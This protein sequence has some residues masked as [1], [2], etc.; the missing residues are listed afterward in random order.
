MECFALD[1]LSI[2]AWPA[3][4]SPTACQAIAST[5][6][7]PEQ[8]RSSQSI[9]EDQGH[10]NV[11]VDG[12]LVHVMEGAPRLRWLP[13]IT[14]TKAYKVPWHVD[15]RRG[16]DW[17]LCLYL[18]AVVDGG[19]VFRSRDGRAQIRP[20]FEQGT[21]V[22]FDIRLEHRT[23]DYDDAAMR[24]VLGLRAASAAP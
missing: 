21:I 20:P 7:W 23:D 14:L 22:L 12:L 18:A 8:Q 16:A 4:L 6:P 1:A 13:S 17:K 2:F 15:Q 5:L 11:L 3:A 9:V 19:T 10:V 24:R